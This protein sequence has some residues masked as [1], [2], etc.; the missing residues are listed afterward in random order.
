MVAADRSFSVVNYGAL[1][2]GG[3]TTQQLSAASSSQFT[4][5]N[6]HCG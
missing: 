4:L 2:E 6:I 3:M 5:D 1:T